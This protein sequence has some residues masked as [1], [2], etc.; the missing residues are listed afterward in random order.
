MNKTFDENISKRNM[1]MHKYTKYA[2]KPEANNFN[3]QFK[4]Y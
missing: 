4:G 2:K 1:K 3:S